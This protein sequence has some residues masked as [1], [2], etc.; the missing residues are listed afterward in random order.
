MTSLTAVAA[1]PVRRAI[2][3]PNHARA[4][5]LAIALVFGAC[6]S[7]APAHAQAGERER[8]AAG[9]TL[10]TLDL[11]QVGRLSGLSLSPD[12]KHVV[13]RL[14]RDNVAR[15]E[16]E[17]TWHRVRLEDGKSN[18]VCDAGKPLW[19]IN[20]Y[21]DTSV[22]QWSADGKWIYVRR[23]EKQQVQ[24]WRCSADGTRREQITQADADVRD[25]ILEGNRTLHVAL[26]GATR[27]EILEAEG[28]EYDA[29][30]L[31]DQTTIPGF[32]IVRSFPHNGRMATYRTLRPRD[33]MWDRTP[34][35]GD[36]P[37]RFVSID[38]VDRAL[39]PASAKV[40]EQFAEA[41]L[42]SGHPQYDPLARDII[43]SADGLQ[44]V[45]VISSDGAKFQIP[46]RPRS[47]TLMEWTDTSAGRT[48]ICT[49][50]ICTDADNISPVGW[51]LKAKALVFQ[52]STFGVAGLHVWDPA[53]NTVATILSEETDI[54]SDRSGSAGVCYLAGAASAS[55]EV[56][57]LAS[58]ADSPARVIAV[59][60][61]TGKQ[62]VLFDPNEALRHGSLGVAQKV[63]IADRWG[64]RA[65]GYLILPRSWVDLPE[66]ARP[67]LP[68]VITS[69]TCPGFLT[70]GS[71][72]DVPEH[73]LAGL[74][75]AAICIDMSGDIARSGAGFNARVDGNDRMLD[76]FEGALTELDKSGIVD[77]DRVVVTGFSAS[78]SAVTYALFKSRRFTSSIITTQGYL[79]PITCY[80]DS[81]Q[82]R[83]R[84]HNAQYWSLPYDGPDGRFSETSPAAHVAEIKTPLLMQLADVE[85]QGMMQ[86]H[87]AMLDYDRPVEMYVFPDEYHN[88]RQPRHRLAVYNRNVDWIEFWLRGSE[89]ADGDAKAYARWR[90]MRDRQCELFTES[91]IAGKPWYCRDGEI[92]PGPQGARG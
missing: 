10:G 7:S 70:G 78:A 91:A 49:A 5:A 68:L 81:A 21:L 40:E 79:D 27:T 83:C 92:P 41:W 74:G 39:R 32:P 77:P 89:R 31:M 62:R 33:A 1:G 36:R 84:A 46:V 66:G 23:L 58:E 87:A 14:D 12:Q 59:R 18:A 19:D 37:P 56:I 48:A 2:D 82:G 90:G 15:N 80:L 54:G 47:G 43:T 42:R 69:Y 65:Y 75:Y 11:V 20:G 8:S 67:R 38:L 24:I 6:S 25:F 44:T 53:A 4:I 13:F 52:T 73:V 72:G 51:A 55:G 28:R 35:L 3:R 63:E 61:S 64:G 17:L 50:D 16:T 30:V 34:L 71:G 60:L 29:G 88:K 22:A 85:Y 45:Q 86:L 26:E 76:F 57:C 9:Q